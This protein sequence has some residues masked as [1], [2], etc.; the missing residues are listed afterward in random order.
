[1]NPN[2]GSRKRRVGLV[3]ACWGKNWVGH[4]GSTQDHGAVSLGWVWGGL[5]WRA[6]GQVARSEAITGPKICLLVG[7]KIARSS[8]AM[9]NRNAAV[10]GEAM[11]N[12][13]MF[14]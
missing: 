12:V 11:H 9:S 6:L 5:R 3:M 10:H 13:K 8:V 2:G 1:M 4:V 7:H 14:S